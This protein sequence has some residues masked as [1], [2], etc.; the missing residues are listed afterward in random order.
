M[1]ATS[2]CTACLK[3]EGA[4]YD[5]VIP[6]DYM[7]SRMIEEDMLEP[8]DFANIPNF[9][10]IDPALLKPAYDPENLYSVPYMWGLL[11]VIY[12]T[13]MVDETPRPA[14]ATMFDED[15]SGQILM[16]DNSRD[17]LG[18][19]L[20]CWAIPTTPRIPLRSPRRW[21][22]SSSRSLWSSPTAWTT[23]LRRCR[24]ARWP[25]APTTTATT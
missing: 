1:R 6:S 5:V 8:L 16:F 11:G 4:S 7:I 17:T 20:R 15:Y 22:C 21:T 2:R 23:S 18:I 10:D 13:T 14:G 25:S 19:A 3:N 12:N 24:A 9:S